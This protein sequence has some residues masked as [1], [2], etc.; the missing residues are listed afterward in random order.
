MIRSLS[1]ILVLGTT[2]TFSLLSQTQSRLEDFRAKTILLFTPHPDDDTFCCA[3]VL[4]LLAKGGNRI[5]IVIYTN[6]DKGSYDPEMTSEHLASIR[7][8]EEE[9]ACRIL[10]IPKQNIQW[11][12]YHD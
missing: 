5:H 12:E 2:A 11:L 10:G 8:H 7:M 6:D 3:G 4:A 9:E 1:L